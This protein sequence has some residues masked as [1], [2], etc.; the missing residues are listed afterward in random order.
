MPGTPGADD[1]LPSPP[2]EGWYAPP[3]AGV[4]RSAEDRDL[5]CREPGAEG[6]SRAGAV[7]GAPGGTCKVMSDA[8]IV[9]VGD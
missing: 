4:R 8:S 7:P 6:K 5:S 1:V 2:P 9:S 3:E